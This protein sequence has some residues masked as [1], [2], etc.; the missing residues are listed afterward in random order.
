MNQEL[1]L[2]KVQMNKKIKGFKKLSKI[3]NWR[4]Q[5]LL[6]EKTLKSK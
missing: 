2:M 3:L 4:Q 1:N 5:S 6:K